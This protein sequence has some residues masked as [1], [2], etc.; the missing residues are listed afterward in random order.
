MKKNPKIIILGGGPT[1]LGAAWR[2]R[3][4][5]YENWVLY[6]KNAFCGGLS[7]TFR[8]EQGFFWD[9]GGHVIHSHYKYFD[10][11]LSKVL[12][13]DFYRHQR[14]SWI[15]TTNSWVPY[16]FQNNLRYLTKE[17]QLECVLGVAKA[18]IE[19]AK[20]AKNF[21]EWI[22]NV[23]GHGIAKYFLFPDNFKRWATPLNKMDKGW[24]AD[25]IS[26]VDFK[27]ILE[28]LIY[29]KDDI[30]WGPNNTF[31]F[32]KFGGTGEISS[33]A[34]EFL[35][36]N[37][38]SGRGV[39]SVDLAQKQVV[40]NNGQ[41]DSFD[42]LIS[43]VPLDKFLKLSK[44]IPKQ[45]IAMVN[46]LAHNNILVVGVGL[47]KEIKTTK[48]WVYFTDPDVPFY[49]LSYFHNYSPFNVPEGNP[50]KFSSLMCEVSYSRYKKENKENIAER[51]IRGLIKSGI[52][53]E[54]DRTKIIS[55]VVYDVPYAY[56]IPTLGRDKIL[57]SVQLFLMKKGIYS[58]GRFGAWKYE[59]GNMDH[60]FM[61]GVEAVDK[62]LNNKKETI[63][64]L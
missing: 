24:I 60:S 32:P 47:K 19:K 41:K 31:I 20:K 8:D 3:E 39:K 13:K 1:G 26:V 14:E 33:R 18:D 12:K 53:N 42:Y 2:L 11:F 35:K 10:R 44:D 58:R 52:V 54:S 38:L 45:L 23:F 46:R 62:I 7:S 37:V 30:S 43:T 57:K 15:K 64:S 5:G 36:D 51:C 6:E 16:P 63:W 61:Q 29:E 9:V 56:P 40:F 59:I 34:A 49:R 25:R 27:R 4:L 22:I 17:V 28:N 50:K 48:C 55:R 21:E